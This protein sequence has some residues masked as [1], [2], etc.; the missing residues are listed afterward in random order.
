MYCIYGTH[1]VQTENDE[2]GQIK[3]TWHA[4]HFLLLHLLF[5]HRLYVFPLPAKF[6][7]RGASHAS[8][9]ELQMAAQIENLTH[10]SARAVVR[11]R[12]SFGWCKIRTYVQRFA[13][14][15]SFD[16]MENDSFGLFVILYIRQVTSSP[17]V[18]VISTLY[19]QPKIVLSHV[20]HTTMR[21]YT[22]ENE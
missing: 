10:T 16:T 20:S 5:F 4:Q 12:L 8:Y 1:C 3:L 15:I 22:D 9:T 6:F 2:M 13:A 21:L 11:N 18:V 14:S 7:H 19:T 17:I